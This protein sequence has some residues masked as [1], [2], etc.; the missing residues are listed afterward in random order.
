MRPCS[1]FRAPK[2][3]R[4]TD[5]QA[6]PSKTV[7]PLTRGFSRAPTKIS[8]S[9]GGGP[10]GQP[11]PAQPLESAIFATSPSPRISDT[12]CGETSASDRL[13]SGENYVPDG[14]A[15]A[16]LSGKALVTEPL[17]G[18]LSAAPQ[19]EA[20][21]ASELLACEQT[22]VLQ[23]RVI[24]ADGTPTR[25]SAG[26]N[27]SGGNGIRPPAA[28]SS[29][30][31]SPDG[32]TSGSTTFNHG[33][34]SAR[35]G[36]LRCTA[37]E[38][39][40]EA[41]SSI[42][43]PK[44]SPAR[45]HQLLAQRL[46]QQQQQKHA[47]S[48]VSRTAQRQDQRTTEKKQ[49][50]HVDIRAF[51]PSL[52]SRRILTRLQGALNPSV[53]YKYRCSAG[54]GIQV[55]VNRLETSPVKL[56]NWRVSWQEL[57]C[58][59]PRPYDA[60]KGFLENYTVIRGMMETYIHK[61]T[62]IVFQDRCTATHKEPHIY[63]A[64]LLPPIHPHD[65]LTATCIQ[66]YTS[67]DVWLAR[68]AWRR[69]AVPNS[70]CIKAESMQ[71]T[72]PK[73]IPFMPALNRE[74]QAEQQRQYRAATTGRLLE[75]SGPLSPLYVHGTEAK[76]PLHLWIFLGGK[77]M[78]AL[79]GL[80][81]AWKMLR[82]ASEIPPSEYVES[83]E[84]IKD[85]DAP[86]GLETENGCRPNGL[87]V[88][89]QYH[90]Q[91]RCVTQDQTAQAAAWARGEVPS[92]SEGGNNTFS[93][94]G[95]FLYDMC[96]VNKNSYY[97]IAFL[98]V[99]IPGYGNSTG[100]PSPCTIRS[101]VLQAVK[102]GIQ[103]LIEHHQESSIVL[104][105]L[106]Y[107]LGCAV[108]CSLAADL[109]ACFSNDAVYATPSQA[110]G[111]QQSWTNIATIDPDLARSLHMEASSA[112]GQNDGSFD[113]RML[114]FR[115]AFNVSMYTKNG[116]DHVC[117]V[118]G[119]N[120]SAG[121]SGVKLAVNRLILLAPFTSTQAMASKVAASAI[122]GGSFLSRAVSGFVSKQI[123]WNNKTQLESLLSTIKQLQETTQV[124]VFSNFRIKILHGDKDSVIPWTMGFE[125]FNELASL[126]KHL[127]LKIPINFQRLHGETHATILC[128]GSEQ[129]ILESC[130]SP[131]RLHPAAP[132]A[133]LKFY[134]KEVHLPETL[135]HRGLYNSS[136]A[137]V[138]EMSTFG[139]KQFPNTHQQMRA[140]NRLHSHG[141][142]MHAPAVNPGGSGGGSNSS[143]ACQQ[144]FVISR[145]NTIAGVP[146]Q[147]QAM[148]QLMHSRSTALELLQASGQGIQRMTPQ[149]SSAFQYS[150][151]RNSG[152]SAIVLNSSK[153]S[154]QSASVLP[155]KG[156]GMTP[157]PC[158]ALRAYSSARHTAGYS[159]ERHFD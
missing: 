70:G 50:G 129:Y 85:T 152:S 69:S 47:L 21:F 138:R 88:Y 55:P 84:D 74:D 54:F 142:Q 115:D 137:E 16:T 158:R 62:D 42:A 12:S 33:T 92:E 64:Y 124:P 68:G 125:L 113:D 90:K 39:L 46:H 145:A 96:G 97:R 86:S 81:I 32:K 114:T 52:K 3:R 103:E 131:Y 140:S 79:D 109:A 8:K 121:Y 38:S 100:H 44:Q 95:P 15:A 110:G 13:S 108:A 126:K 28:L 24:S 45:R 105:I 134:S 91:R 128:G 112:R 17:G 120:P 29:N 111:G 117:K 36:T 116:I 106:G 156:V 155:G 20:S 51:P 147:P 7:S 99:D 6:A 76:L 71:P 149:S 31:N 136:L 11:A 48:Q 23:S 154:H 135:P 93:A 82:W 150:G 1:L 123:S 9:K 60:T 66:C 72:N 49:K 159:S 89:R 102:H 143:T 14:R 35:T 94:F 41:I 151:G 132:L 139:P 4:S 73:V 98:M 104:N 133:L 107:S 40:A 148:L 67:E 122:G 10:I 118:H 19:D 2:G 61:L 146:S 58:Y 83:S 78:Q 26:G 101:A 53:M 57:L 80:V 27:T 144:A 22:L 119:W 34:P 75:R 130:F 37:M 127:E 141:I 87:E 59:N 157:H 18:S 25:F 153:F 77:D 30:G 63:H 56:S 5:G 43:T 65:W